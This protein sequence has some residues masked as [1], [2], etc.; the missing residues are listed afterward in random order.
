MKRVDVFFFLFVF[1]FF[2]RIVL[3]LRRCFV[4]MRRSAIGLKGNRVEIPDSPAAVIS[5]ETLSLMCP[6]ASC[7]C[8]FAGRR[9]GRRESEDLQGNV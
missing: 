5:E 3:T 6:Y 7:H 9:C 1:F 2:L 8:Y 4:P